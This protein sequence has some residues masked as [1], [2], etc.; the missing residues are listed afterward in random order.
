MISVYDIS[1]RPEGLAV[2]VFA[3]HMHQDLMQ[4]GKQT[5]ADD[6]REIFGWAVAAGIAT[7]LIFASGISAL[8]L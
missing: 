1:P 8:F 7:I 4:I 2:D 5:W 6:S 3:L